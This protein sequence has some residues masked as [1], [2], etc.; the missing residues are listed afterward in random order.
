VKVYLGLFI[1]FLGLVIA[2]GSNAEDL[3]VTAPEIPPTIYATQT[4]VTPTAT[5]TSTPYVLDVIVTAP[6]IRVYSGP[7]TENPI[8]QTLTQNDGGKVVGRNYDCSW[9]AMELS[10]GEIGWL[11]TQFHRVQL[12]VPCNSIPHGIY[13]LKNGT[14]VLDRRIQGGGGKLEIENSAPYDAVVM[15]VNKAD[16]HYS[17]FIHRYSSYSLEEIPDGEYSIYFSL[18]N[19]WD[20]VDLRFTTNVVFYKFEDIFKFE[21]KTTTTKIWYSVWKIGLQPVAGGT[22]NAE[23]LSPEL[24][25]LIKNNK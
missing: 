12:N 10:S 15:L 17:C 19:D 5:S 7:G 20:L 11:N 13:R 22:A 21:T 23:Q 25:P 16:P 4:A 8:I 2:C 24:F 18:G 3:Q 6:S 1:I 9:L 14:I